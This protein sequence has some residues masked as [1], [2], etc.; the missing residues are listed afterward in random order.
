MNV[1]SYNRNA[2]ECK[3]INKKKTL[4]A[5]WF[6]I[7][8]YCVCNWYWSKKEKKICEEGKCYKKYGNVNAR[9]WYFHGDANVQ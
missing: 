4:D 6:V 3:L 8:G 9:D 2:Y 5:R 7:C 1:V